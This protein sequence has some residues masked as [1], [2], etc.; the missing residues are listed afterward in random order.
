MQLDYVLGFPQAPVGREYYIRIF[1]KVQ[2]EIEWVLKVNNN[3]YR[4][5]QIGRVWNEFPVI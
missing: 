1:F 4:Q 3:I 2:S 5:R